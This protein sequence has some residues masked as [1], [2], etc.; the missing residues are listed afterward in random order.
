MSKRTSTTYNA[1]LR[2]IYARFA[3]EREKAGQ[4]GSPIS[5]DDVYDFA[6]RNNLWTPPRID[7]RKRFRNDLARALREDYFT[8]ESGRTVR[9]YHAAKDIHIDQDGIAIQEV[10]WVDMLSDPPP[11]RKHMEVALKQRRQQIVGDCHQL[12]NDVDHYN[13]RNSSEKPIRMLWDFTDDLADLDQSTDYNP[14][15][16]D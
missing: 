8:D 4:Q 14:S 3:E 1:S 10:L 11:P 16:E 7:I 9:R 6:D 5:L 13:E 2:T 15:D 12:K